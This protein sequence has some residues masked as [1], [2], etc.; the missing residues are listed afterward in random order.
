MTFKKLDA[1]LHN[2]FDAFEKKSQV[3]SIDRVSDYQQAK[4]NLSK[5]IFNIKFVFNLISPLKNA[6]KLLHS[7]DTLNL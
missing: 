7:K 6:I 5:W 4:A 3:I 2:I 1:N